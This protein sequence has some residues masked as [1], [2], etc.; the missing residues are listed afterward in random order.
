MPP[1][2]GSTTQRWECEFGNARCT[3]MHA[4]CTA[5]QRRQAPLPLHVTKCCQQARSI[6]SDSICR[7]T[8]VYASWPTMPS[9]AP[10]SGTRVAGLRTLARMSV[11][12]G[13][14]CVGGAAR[15]LWPG[16]AAKA[17]YIPWAGA[18]DMLGHLSSTTE[19]AREQ[20]R[21]ANVRR[22]LSVQHAACSCQARL[23]LELWLSSSGPHA[24]HHSGPC[25][26]I[27]T[28]RKGPRQRSKPIWSGNRVAENRRC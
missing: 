22:S 7:H 2:A 10:G 28:C 1:R 5:T 14:A 9:P 25:L 26:S 8:K 18:T 27:A 12:R 15:Q 11:S 16:C 23:A 21:H 20:R 19:R 13:R 3:S 4:V 24:L 17:S 6:G